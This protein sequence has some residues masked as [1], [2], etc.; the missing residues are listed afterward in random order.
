M[1]TEAVV[2]FKYDTCAPSL[3][4]LFVACKNLKCWLC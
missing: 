3:D 2:T 1:V 4:M